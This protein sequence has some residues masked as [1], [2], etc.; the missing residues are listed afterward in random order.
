M[1]VRTWQWISLAILAL[2]MTYEAMTEPSSMTGIIAG[3]LFG[4]VATQLE[5]NR[6]RGAG[7]S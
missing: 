1:T 2:I 7:Q 3:V 4:A 5:L 6:R